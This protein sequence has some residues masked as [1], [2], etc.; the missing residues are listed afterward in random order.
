MS[1]R[2]EDCRNADQGNQGLN[3]FSLLDRIGGDEKQILTFAART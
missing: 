2:T 3:Y 1:E